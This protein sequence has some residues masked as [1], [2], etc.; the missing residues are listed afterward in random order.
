MAS[1]LRRRVGALGVKVGMMS[2][3]DG[4][5]A[6][7]PLTCV[8]LDS[9]RVT[10]V[11]TP[12]SDG[13]L[14]LQVGCGVRKAHRVPKAQLGHF[15]KS[16]LQPARR[17]A[18][19]RVSEDGLLPVGTEISAR[20]FVPGQLVDVQGTTKGKG[21]AGV[22]KRWG[23]RGG[24]AS[25]GATKIHRKGGSIGNTGPS[26]VFKG[27][28]MMGRM[29]GATKTQENCLVYK[30]DALR[31]L[32]YLRGCVPGAQGSVIR[33]RDAQKAGAREQLAAAADLPFPTFTGEAAS[34]DGE[35]E[36]VHELVMPLG[37]D[38]LKE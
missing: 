9:V 33:L 6:V 16:G 31:N 20:H 1:A 17:V 10:Q 8:A 14:A 36:A 25:H 34:E 19:F 37:E 13:Y 29:G 15:R 30:I 24:P 5:G 38:P 3:F 28:K 27:K 11:K 7:H 4:Y 12:E 22:M 2:V 18:E 23:F 26:H 32:V 35:S 21:T